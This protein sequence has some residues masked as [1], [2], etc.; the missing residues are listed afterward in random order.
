M[1]LEHLVETLSG[2]SLSLHLVRYRLVLFS[3][4]SFVPL[5]HPQISF[6]TKHPLKPI[7]ISYWPITYPEV[8]LKL[9]IHPCS[10]FAVR[11]CAPKAPSRRGR[12][13][14][15]ENTLSLRR[16]RVSSR[17]PIKMIS[18]I[19]MLTLLFY[20]L[21]ERQKSL[22]SSSQQNARNTRCSLSDGTTQ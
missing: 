12:L 15:F 6:R 16:R 22:G 14:F 13:G 17:K 5:I 2:G 7:W 3:G 8:V 18:L 4:T 19:G 9:Q 20:R 1:P 10:P 11:F 21:L